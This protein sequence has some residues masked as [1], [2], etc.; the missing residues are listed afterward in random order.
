M[1]NTELESLAAR[2]RKTYPEGYLAGI[3]IAW[4]HCLMALRA[5]VHGLDTPVKILQG[6]YCE[7]RA[8]ENA[9]DAYEDEPADHEIDTSVGMI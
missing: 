2:L 7:L 9:F 5:P 8:F 1:L 4:P 3:E 6:S